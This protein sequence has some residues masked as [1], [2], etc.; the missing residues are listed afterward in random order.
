MGISIVQKSGELRSGSAGDYKVRSAAVFT[1]NWQNVE[2]SAAQA[3]HGQP[4]I[5][6]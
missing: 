6:N 4:Y 1:T 3:M 5:P 2:P